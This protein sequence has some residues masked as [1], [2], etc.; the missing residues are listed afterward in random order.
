MGRRYLL[1]NWN[2]DKVIYHDAFFEL[3]A[4]PAL[5]AGNISDPSGAFGSQGWLWDPGAQ[6]TVRV[7]DAVNVVFSYGRDI[8]SGQNT[9]FGATVP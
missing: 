2:W 8:R 5:D 3:K 1:W 4:G 7:L 9:F 6:L